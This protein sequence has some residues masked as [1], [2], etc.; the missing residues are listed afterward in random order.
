MNACEI[1]QILNGTLRFFLFPAGSLIFPLLPQ[2]RKFLGKITGF[3]C[4]AIVK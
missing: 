2:S 4:K 3:A 1:F